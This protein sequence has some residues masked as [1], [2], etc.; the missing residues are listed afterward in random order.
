MVS[1]PRLYF[2]VVVVRVVDAFVLTIM[3]TRLVEFVVFLL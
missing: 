2:F 3:F 1:S